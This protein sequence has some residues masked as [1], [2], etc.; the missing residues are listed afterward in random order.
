MTYQ[1]PIF[2]VILESV[3]LAINTDHHRVLP[4]RRLDILGHKYLT[5]L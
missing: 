1:G 5:F 4:G 3:K 2:R